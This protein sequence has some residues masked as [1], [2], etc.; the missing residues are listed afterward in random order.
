MSTQWIQWT[1]IFVIGASM[2][3]LIYEIA[4]FRNKTKREKEKLVQS[5]INNEAL[6]A[7]LNLLTQTISMW[8]K[9]ILELKAKVVSKEE[10]KHG[11]QKQG[12]RASDDKEELRREISKAIGTNTKENPISTR[13]H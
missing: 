10:V 1:A 12:S 9:A 7:Q 5:K 13:G 2:A 8:G 6:C 4:Y 3:S 11:T